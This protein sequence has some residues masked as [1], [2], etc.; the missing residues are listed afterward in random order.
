MREYECGIFDFRNGKNTNTWISKD[1]PIKVE[2]F[3]NVLTVATANAIEVFDVRKLIKPFIKENVK[4]LKDFYY[5]PNI[6]KI[7]IGC[8]NRLRVYLTDY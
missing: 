4:G 8:E 1:I 7:F 2:A 6:N 5:E 3:S